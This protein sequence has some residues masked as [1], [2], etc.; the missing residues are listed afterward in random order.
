MA[1][2]QRQEVDLNMFMIM[3]LIT[4]TETRVL[5]LISL[6]YKSCQCVVICVVIQRDDD[7]SGRFAGVTENKCCRCYTNITMSE[8]D[9]NRK[10]RKIF[11][12]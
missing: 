5:E 10:R 7:K 4:V 2:A 1:Q 8:D 6:L 9:L 3:T 11:K 12:I